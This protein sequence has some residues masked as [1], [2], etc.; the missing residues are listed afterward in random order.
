M[1]LAVAL[2]VC[3]AAHSKAA[4]NDM[5]RTSDTETARE[6][7]AREVAENREAPAKAS[8]HAQGQWYAMMQQSAG[9][10]TSAREPK[11]VIGNKGR[12]PR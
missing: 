6:S 11:L 10:E 7:R 9:Q 2:R 5:Y 12:L 3:L 8:K 4:S 1:Y